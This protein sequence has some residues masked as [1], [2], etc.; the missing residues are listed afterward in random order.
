MSDTTPAPSR[1]SESGPESAPQR[2]VLVYD[3]DCAFCRKWILRWH[4][5]T[6][7]QIEYAPYQQA[8]EQYP[9]IPPDEFTKA[10]YLIEPD[11]A[12]YRAAEAVFRSLSAAPGRRW[13]YWAYRR[14]PLV[15]PISERASDFASPALGG[16]VD[17]IVLI[18]W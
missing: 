18:V 10:V 11:G 1:P 9:H 4:H 2:P 8:A 17:R 12:T 15:R 5:L 6:G 7:D 13:M 3:G 14:V 16:T